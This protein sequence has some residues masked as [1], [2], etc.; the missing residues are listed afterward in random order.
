MKWFCVLLIAIFLSLGSSASP[1]NDASRMQAKLR[2]LENNGALAHPDETP[3]KFTEAEINS[4]LNSGLVVL[5]DGVQALHFSG[6]AG[7]LTATA[8]V[9]FDKIKSGR[10]SSN[11]LLLIFN[12]TH[13]ILVA[14]HAHGAGHEGFVH[15]DSLKLDG[16]EVPE[17]ALRLFVEKYLQSKYPDVGI[18]SRFP[19]PDRIDTA[20]I[21]DHE[22]TVTQK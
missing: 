7:A 14:A 8:R 1:S 10:G 9:D 6:Q 19:L 12:G 3:T 5:P 15:V 21:G 16:V 18:D 20:R 17:F 13:D 11:P 4:Y 2:R 22:L